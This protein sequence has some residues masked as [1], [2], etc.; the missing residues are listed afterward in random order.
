MLDLQTAIAK[1]KITR[2]SEAGERAFLQR[3]D[4]AFTATNFTK[5]DNARM[6][7]QRGILPLPGELP[8]FTFRLRFIGSQ[9]AAGLDPR[10]TD[11]RTPL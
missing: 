9:A 10:P 7:I 4:C 3:I 11:G 6:H 1:A 5:D 2:K 8:G